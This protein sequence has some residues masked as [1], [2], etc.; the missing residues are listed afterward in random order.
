M[1]LISLPSA[2]VTVNGKRPADEQAVADLLTALGVDEGDHTADTP[3]RVAKAWAE[4]L[5]GYR[6][7]P[8][9]HLE[10]N[11]SAPPEPGL[12][13][14]SG[15]RLVSTC[16]HHL[17]PFIGT[18]TVAYRPAP[19]QNVVGLSKLARLVHG[20]A[21]R[22]QVQERIGD[23]VATALV[24]KLNP[25]WAAVLI[26]ATHQC[27]SLRGVREPEAATTTRTVR[28]VPVES[29]MAVVNEAHFRSMA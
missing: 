23:Q 22:L 15:I 24:E 9:V 18:A 3:R 11:F 20:Y 19:G 26:T 14:V 29:D 8:A 6:E 13:I 10:R 17:L 4:M 5:A 27:M 28:G 12:V 1:T 2:A 25:L 21:R 16:A 7:D